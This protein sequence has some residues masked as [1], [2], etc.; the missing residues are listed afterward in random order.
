M[1]TVNRLVNAHEREQVK[2]VFDESGGSTTEVGVG[3]A[4]L[5]INQ[6]VPYSKKLFD[7]GTF[8]QERIDDS[9]EITAL[10]ERRA[11]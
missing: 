3:S 1:V 8:V 6:Q 11:G 9:Q 2:V 7:L 4:T 10:W 5:L